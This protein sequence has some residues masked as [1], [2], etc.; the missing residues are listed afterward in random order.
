MGIEHP[1]G[2]RRIISDQRATLTVSLTLN[3]RLVIRIIEIYER[4][5]ER[6]NFEASFCYICAFDSWIFICRTQARPPRS[7]CSPA[8]PANGQARHA[9]TPTRR[10]RA[11]SWTRPP[12]DPSTSII[13]PFNAPRSSNVRIT[14]RW[15]RVN[16]R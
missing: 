3:E 7:W 11:N 12:R 16:S 13:E 15:E 8:F 14:S 5:F 9:A 1:S 4:K 2:D 6:K 10:S